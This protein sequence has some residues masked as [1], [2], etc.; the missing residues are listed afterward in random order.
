MGPEPPKADGHGGGGLSKK[1]RGKSGE[2]VLQEGRKSLEERVKEGGRE[3]DL[4]RRCKDGLKIPK[5]GI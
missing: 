1:E 2:K 4:S 3:K 5:R